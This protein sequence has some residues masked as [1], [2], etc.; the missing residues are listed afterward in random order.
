LRI[1]ELVD[2]QLEAFR[3]EFATVNTTFARSRH[4]TPYDVLIVAS[5]IQA[6]AAT[7][8][9]FRLVAS[10]IY[11]R[12]ADGM[13]LGSDA[14]TRY[15][16]GNYTTPLTQSQIDSPSR[17]NTRNHL[18][19]PPTPI[20]SPGLATIEAA[21]HPASSH[22]LYFIV[23]PCGNGA[24]AYATNYQQFLVEDQAYQAASAKRRGN[25]PEFCV[26]KR[27]G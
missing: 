11:N 23:K 24:L 6:E 7:V 22:Y 17:W 26:A 3:K 9:D 16:T 21:A 2:D 19:L 5:I 14:T 27:R 4:L 18:G 10:V 13:S 20:N 12:L 15:A 8:H 1:G 25:S